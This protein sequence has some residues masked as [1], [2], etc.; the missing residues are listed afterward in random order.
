[1]NGDAWDCV[2]RLRE[3]HAVMGGDLLPWAATALAEATHEAG[4]LRREL[5]ERE[6]TVR[7][8]RAQVEEQARQIEV[9]R[10]RRAGTR[11]RDQERRRFRVRVRR[12]LKG[13]E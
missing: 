1:M 2:L 3:A 8:L 13:E 9:L 10:V 7:V 5:D 11:A 4:A 6:S 12:I